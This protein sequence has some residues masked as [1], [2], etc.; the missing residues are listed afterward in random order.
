[1]AVKVIPKIFG[2][3]RLVDE[4]EL[5]EISKVLFELLPRSRRIYDSITISMRGLESSSPIYVPVD[6]LE[7]YSG[8]V[9][10]LFAEYDDPTTSVSFVSSE[11]DAERVSMGDYKLK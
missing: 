6:E 8:I 7:N 11:K 1:M 4:F 10:A 2:Q 3:F 9:V 5:P